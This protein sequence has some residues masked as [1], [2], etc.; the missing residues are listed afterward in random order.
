M[1]L[2]LVD[3]STDNVNYGSGSGLDSPTLTAATL[4]FWVYPTTVANA[5][6]QVIGKKG[7][8]NTG[9]VVVKRGA[10]GTNWAFLVDR[11]TTD[12]GVDITGVQANVWQYMAYSWNVGATDFHSYLGTLSA[13]ATEISA[14]VATGSGA[15]VDDSAESLIVG[16]GNQNATGMRMGIVQIVNRVLTLAEI[17][18]LQFH[19]YP[20]PGTVLY[21]HLGLTGTGTQPDWSGN[22]NTGTVTG[23]TVSEHVPLGP[24]FGWDSDEAYIVAAAAAASDPSRMLMGIGI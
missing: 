20:I 6:R 23:A 24:F 5:L 22:G 9:W 13:V 3:N 14:G 8:A 16:Q 15:Q 2:T 17:Q 4:M 11:A 7:A 10:D 19:P 12:A 21:T 1:A 18:H